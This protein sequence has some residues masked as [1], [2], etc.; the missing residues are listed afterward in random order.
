MVRKTE[1]LRINSSNFSESI[2]KA[3]EILK[4]RGTVAFPT[5]TVYGLGANALDS[6]SVHKIFSAKGRP[7]DNPLIVHIASKEQVRDISE[8][9]PDNTF[10][11]MDAFWPG[12]LT[13]ILKRKN[14]VPDV[15]T[16]GLNTVAI[17]MPDNATAI[18]LIKK[19]GVPIAAP[20]ANISGKPS[21]TTAEHVISDLYGKIDAIVDG[22][23]VDIGVESTVVDMTS[24]K[25]ILL[26]P[27]GIGVEDLKKYIPD[28]ETGYNSEKLTDK[29]VKS[30][31]MKYIHYSPSS[32]VVLVEGFYRV[33][34]K[35]NQV[36]SDYHKNGLYVGLLVTNETAD[37]ITDKNVNIFLLGN[38]DN[39]KKV[40]NNL[41]KGLRT[42]DNLNLDVIIVDGSIKH[43]GIGS[44]VINRL[45]KAANEIIVLEEGEYIET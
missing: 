36:I 45:Q 27:G 26:R 24:N 2:S 38:R 21:P 6:I 7:P 4:N 8:D 25:P 13:L 39:I 44:A 43:E 33:S 28:I 3:A 41:F 5:E 16:G 30:P 34:D 12:P 14:F 42:L 35:I 20:S 15:T 10:L 31:G 37:Q 22:G 1:I 32:K 18:E 11:L 29:K 17:R 40:A 9:I 23:A 19:A